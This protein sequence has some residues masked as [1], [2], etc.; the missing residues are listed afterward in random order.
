MA[1]QL[2]VVV[3]GV[4]VKKAG[5]SSDLLATALDPTPEEISGYSRERM[6][7]DRL[8][9]HST[10]DFELRELRDYNDD[11]KRQTFPA[12][13]RRYRQYG[14]D[15]QVRNER[16]I[17]DFYWGDI[18]TFSAGTS[19]L[20]VAAIK[21]ILG[22]GHT[23]RENAISAWGPGDMRS[24][25]ADWIVRTIHGPIAAFN[26]VMFAGAVVWWAAGKLPADISAWIQPQ[27]GLAVAA[28]AAAV[29]YWQ[30]RRHRSFLGR[31]LYS[32]VLIAALLL[33]ASEIANRSPGFRDRLSF[34]DTKV[35][36]YI[37][38]E[39]P[40]PYLRAAEQ[41]AE[42]G[43]L[44]E[45][46]RESCS[47]EPDC[48]EALGQGIFLSGGRLLAFGNLFWLVTLALNVTLIVA[49]VFKPRG[50]GK[51]APLLAPIAASGMSALWML[52]LTLVWTAPGAMGWKILP[53]SGMLE[54]GLA[55]ATAIAV[56]VGALAL[57]GVAVVLGKGRWKKSLP[58]PSEL[59]ARYFAG[60]DGLR[61]DEE[62]RRLIVNNQF[63][64]VFLV[65]VVTLAFCAFFL[66]G[67][68]VMQ[69]DDTAGIGAFLRKLT[70]P[71]TLVLG[72]LGVALVTWAG[73]Q[74][75]MGLEILTDVITYLND[76]DWRWGTAT[77]GSAAIDRL[78]PRGGSAEDAGYF[79][80]ER[81]KDR[82]KVL[83]DE[84]IANERPNHL[85]VV[86]HSQGTV[87]ALD[88]LDECGATWRS[89]LDPK[90]SGQTVRLVTMGSP[91]THIHSHYFPAS[92]KPVNEREH[93]A[94][95]GILSAWINI[96]RVDDFV[97]THVDPRGIWPE[98]HPVPPNG[99]TYYWTD[100]NVFPLLRRFLDIDAPKAAAR[101]ISSPGRAR[102]K[103]R[104]RRR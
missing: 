74:L 10:D 40:A 13:I 102:G 20:L 70:Q 56:I 31:L 38:R 54:S 89:K 84:L 44:C 27:M 42:S 2:I 86:S 17:A 5:V 63:A 71:V 87:I 94:A 15:D 68:A 58:A 45:R 103:A 11:G 33:A 52:F 29:A 55:L 9:P 18:S 101:K 57:A 88:V 66:L 43:P 72:I 61:L 73:S 100:E 104:Q 48:R 95:G 77:P 30:R 69:T 4:G 24:R 65:G 34:A 23:V 75:K 46:V 16:V 98:E 14:E 26:L 8:R 37:C 47:R 90:E 80:R 12:R 28:V 36:A 51:G 83:V 7:Q 82:F 39:K 64:A 78:L 99:H 22:I 67:E 60:M 59:R 35:A 3:H 50:A 96:F 6:A 91:Y 49:S 32:W 92:F 1:K 79:L 21:V 25:M 97:G 85:A 53:H 93:L 62:R 81:I 19:G 41:K 76:Y